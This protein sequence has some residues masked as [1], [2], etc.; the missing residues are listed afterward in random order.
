MLR[1]RGFFLHFAVEFIIVTITNTLQGLPPGALFLKINPY[2]KNL[3]TMH[4][5]RNE[6]TFLDLKTNYRSSN[7]IRGTV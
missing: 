6:F 2:V 1:H 5:N 7:F 4:V 3:I